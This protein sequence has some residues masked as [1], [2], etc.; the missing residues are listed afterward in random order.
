MRRV[1][2]AALVIGIGAATAFGALGCGSPDFQS[3]SQISG[4]RI[5]ASR[6]TKPY[7]KPG[8]TVGI[9][10]LWVDGSAP[11]EGGAVP[12][13]VDIRWLPPCFDPDGDLYYQCY[14]NLGFGQQGTGP[15]S[16]DAGFNPDALLALLPS[17]DH[18]E[19]TLPDDIITRRIPPADMSVVPSG[20]AIVFFLACKGRLG[21]APPGSQARFPFPLACFDRDTGEPL[22]AD[23]FV[24]GYTTI[25]AYDNTTNNNPVFTSMDMDPVAQSFAPGVPIEADAMSDAGM[26]DEAAPSADGADESTAE[27]AATD[28]AADAGAADDAADAGITSDAE[29]DA[30][31][32]D[33]ASS[34]AE[35]ASP[36]ASADAGEA[37]S[38]AGPAEPTAPIAATVVV[39]VDRCT[40]SNRD[41]CPNLR[42]TPHIDKSSAEIDST[43][44]DQN[45][46][47][48]TESLWIDYYATK[49]DFTHTVRLVNDPVALW[50]DDQWTEW[51]APPD[52]GPVRLWGI[53]HDNRGGMTWVERDVIVK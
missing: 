42:L 49:G 18:F 9:D 51:R 14:P 33:D 28:D 15:S 39:A 31:S 30:S 50:N 44:K 26:V 24:P 2:T 21:F 35:A 45:G 23:S 6:K 7:A 53:V 25:Y 19:V 32:A 48:L 37:D 17:G 38:T 10:L 46:N 8:D 3:S 20:T 52:P 40:E 29:L 5:L 27:A 34:A 43:S 16:G 13:P 12:A 47:P 1:A 4:L 22:G 36:D 11:P 41:N